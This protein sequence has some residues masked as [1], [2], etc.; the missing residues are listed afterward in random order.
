V[1]TIP[2]RVVVTG[3]AGFIG[4]HVVAELNRRGVDDITIVDH[5]D[6]RPSK[7]RN[8]DGLRFGTYL[9]RDD[10][11]DRVRRRTF[12]S[13]HAVV[14]LGACSSTTEPDAGYLAENNFRYTRSLC[15]WALERDF[16]FVYASS[17]ATYGDGAAGYSDAHDGLS[18]LRPVNR[19]AKSKHLFDRWAARA[20]ALDRCVG[21]KFFNVYGPCEGHKGDMRSMVLKAFEQV[22]AT[23][24]VKLFRS[25]R[26]GWAHG[27]QAR[28]FVDVRDAAAVTAYFLEPGRASG[29]FN[30]GTGCARTWLDLVTAVCAAMGRQ[31]SV[32]F[33]DMPEAMRA[34]YQYHTEAD[35]S[36]LRT[37]GYATPF[38]D[39]ER[40]V[41]DYVRHL[42]HS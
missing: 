32:E 13:P 9:E 10:F 29:L 8:L 34:G 26:P 16:R 7:A 11:I 19:Y 23:G 1:V 18:K 15:E 20:G 41:R 27:E 33:V 17:A 21:L 14:H 28:D 37:A 35:V 3:G 25:Y 42:S 6:A 4:R 12:A 2:G 22:R 5:L 30:C 36:K 39:L 31:P 40:G 38:I 24:R